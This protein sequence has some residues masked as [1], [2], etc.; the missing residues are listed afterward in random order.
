MTRRLLLLS[1]PALLTVTASAQ[2]KP[3]PATTAPRIG[4]FTLA[5]GRGGTIDFDLGT[6]GKVRVKAVSP[7]LVRFTSAAYE[8]AARTLVMN[9]AGR[10]AQEIVATGAVRLVI[11]QAEAGQ[12]NILTCDRAVYH[13][14]ETEGV[15]RIDLEGNVR[16]LL[17][18]KDLLDGPMETTGSRGHILLRGREQGPFI[19][20]EDA[21]TK[22]TPIET[23]A[24]PKE[25]P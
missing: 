1:L 9:A 22:A 14:G 3:P 17:Y 2:Q 5:V 16:H 10:R 21:Q 20:L 7:V 12:T 6:P 8:G 24:T 15:G 4:E 23:P 25:K 18:V 11:R 13:A 19:H